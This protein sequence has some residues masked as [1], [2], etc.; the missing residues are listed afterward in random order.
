MDLK[1]FGEIQGL[2]DGI[3]IL[4]SRLGF[5]V[6]DNGLPV[7]VY[8]TD[9][10]I[11]VELTKGKASI[12]FNQKIHFFRALGLFVEAARCG[13]DFKIVEEP[14]FTLN[15][16]MV[17]C[18]RNSVVSVKSLKKLLTIMALMGLNLCMMYTEDTYEI[19]DEPYFGYMRG[20]YTF[21]ELKECDD[22]ADIFGIEMMPCIQT[23]GH[24]GQALK[25]NYANDIR[26]NQDILLVGEDKTYEFIENMIKS[27][28]K[29]FRSKRIH[30]GMDEAYFVGRGTYL[31]KHGYRESF[32]LLNEH[33]KRVT[34]ITNK[35]GLKPMMWSDMYFRLGSKTGDYYDLDAVIPQKA[36][37]NA[38]KDVQLVYWDYYHEDEEFYID[39]IRKHK[40]FGRN[41]V[42]AGG[43][44]TWLSLSVNYPKTFLTVNAALKACKKEGIKEIIATAWGDNGAETNIFSGLLGLQ[45]YAEHG[46]SYELDMEKLK[47]RFK[48]CTNGDYDSF[49]DISN[50]D[51]LPGKDDDPDNIFNP[52]KYML[53]QDI[54]MG[55]FDKD[56][57]GTDI[58]NHYS[59]LEENMKR[60]ASLNKEWRDIFYVQQKLCAVLKSKGDIGNRIKKY[61]DKKDITSL[62]DIANKELPEL[63]KRVNDLK[64]AHR[65][66]W[67]KTYK[68][69]GWEVL[70][71]RYGGV[72]ARI[73]TAILRINDY[74]EGKIDRI[75]ELEEERLYFD[76]MKE[77]DL[78]LP[79]CTQYNRI[80]T[81]SLI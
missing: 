59:K 11:E 69:F 9:K 42:F 31:D 3:S 40:A 22:Y 45:L 52:S 27:A 6:S 17:D 34:Q 47:K 32:S 43:I 54:L 38:P 5:N 70:D 28:S 64:A 62:D 57:E 81:S 1:F 33:L 78:D 53:W 66:Q 76:G 61:Y 77:K 8:K 4:S 71:I 74:V 44:W 24:L 72:L 35:Y 56:L 10:N 48:F 13:N 80:A 29:P 50:M 16:P 63:Y 68:P 37:D 25:W 18:S 65:D 23:L 46:Y 15:G 73:E 41:P 51:K 14:Q 20:K 21:E 58:Y 12:G 39:Y 75:E 2:N 19:E 36:I 7:E 26:D 79:V 30:I 49:I 60:H 55:L 67:L